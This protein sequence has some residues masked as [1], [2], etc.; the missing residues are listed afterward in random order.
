MRNL[1]IICTGGTIDGSIDYDERKMTFSPNAKS[2]IKTFI[3]KYLKPEYD[4]TETIVCMLD[5]SDVT[6]EIRESIYGVI[7]KSKHENII[8]AHGTDTLSQ[9]A[10]Y[11]AGKQINKKVILLGAFKPLIFA[12]SDAAFNLGFAIAS[13]ENIRSGVY[14]AMNSRL[15]DATEVKKDFKLQKFV[16]V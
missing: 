16:T 13:F 7:K 1:E 8:I 10:Q 12:P 3:T 11:L 14:V 2:N 6:D 9:T 4:I 15:F 5:S